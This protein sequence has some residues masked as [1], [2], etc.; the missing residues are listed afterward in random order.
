MKTRYGLVRDYL[1]RDE[2]PYFR[3]VELMVEYDQVIGFTP[4]PLEFAAQSDAART[5]ATIIYDM[6]D[7]GLVVDAKTLE[8]I[9]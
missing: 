7:T 1:G 4:V 3:I 9:G 8:I 6:L 2:E 5:I